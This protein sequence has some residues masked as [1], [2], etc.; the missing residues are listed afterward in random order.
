MG[1]AGAAS[2][3]LARRRQPGAAVDYFVAAAEQAERGWAKDHAR[4]LYR[5]ALELVPTE[6][7]ERRS[8]LRRRLASRSQALYHVRTRGCSGSAETSR[9]A[10]GKSAGSR[11][12]R[13]P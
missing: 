5:E 11:R 1:E 2:P 7:A 3:P 6:D 10:G 13:S 4:T 9:L 12:R 8:E